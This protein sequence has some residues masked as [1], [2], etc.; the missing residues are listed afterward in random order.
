MYN[1]FSLD[2]KSILITGASSGI[3]RSTA[4]ECSRLGARVFITGRNEERLEK[5]WNDLDHS[6]S[7]HGKYI[8]DL[9]DEGAIN[10]MVE[11]IPNIDGLVH[12]AGITKTLPVQF[13]DSKN[14]QDIFN[15]NFFAPVAL[16]RLLLKKK[17]LNR[18]SSIV[19]ISSIDGPITGHV[20]NA[21]Y[22]STKGAVSAVVKNMAVE[23]AAKNIRVNAVLPGQI[24]TPLIHNTGISDE[25]LIAD[26]NLYPLK[27]YG[28]PREVAL[29]I[30]YFL[31][32][33]SMFTTGAGLVID[34]GFTLI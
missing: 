5:T 33:A 19:F 30:I 15:V 3:G 10:E 11:G 32:D 26:K 24:E 1:P 34:G 7:A 25:Q 21:I 31:S 9:T 2:N 8:L 18:N 29:A 14:M 20:G 16:T 12:S 28:E 22:S 6:A 17:K 23:L 4:T 13:C 27:R